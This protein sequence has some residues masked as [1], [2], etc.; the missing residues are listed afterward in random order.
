MEKAI[1]FN[2]DQAVTRKG[3]L[4]REIDGASLTTYKS[5]TNREAKM[6]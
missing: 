4:P 3:P 2:I 5:I 1:S 6:Q